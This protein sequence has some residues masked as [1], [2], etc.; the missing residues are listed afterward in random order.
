M[1]RHKHYDHGQRV[2]PAANLQKQIVAGTFEYAVHPLI[3]EQ[4][5]LSEFDACYKNDE[6]DAPAYDP[7]ML[8]KIIH[9]AGEY[10][11]RSCERASDSVG[12]Q[13]SI[14]PSAQPRVVP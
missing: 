3:E 11:S 1:A 7:P 2:M 8:L 6:M 12:T 9:Y 4:L 5:D 13:A 14:G 10:S